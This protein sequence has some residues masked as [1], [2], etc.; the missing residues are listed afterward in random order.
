MSL[1][2]EGLTK[3]IAGIE[4]LAGFVHEEQKRAR[5]RFEE[6]AESLSMVVGLSVVESPIS[7]APVF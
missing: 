6:G 1:D 4:A 7:S 2:Q 3:V 5:K